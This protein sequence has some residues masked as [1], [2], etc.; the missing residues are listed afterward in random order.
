MAESMNDILH[1]NLAEKKDPDFP[2]APGGWSRDVAKAKAAEEGITLG[3]EHWKVIRFL[4]DYYHDHE[5]TDYDGHEAVIDVRDLHKA[6]E[7]QFVGQ[8]GMKHLY[9][10]FPKGPIYQGTLI[11]GLVPP[12]GSTD[13]S[14]GTAM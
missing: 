5:V 11:A 6:L 10:L 13:P 4:Q 8:G 9:L 2:H 3:E 1:P 12:E 14:F 7:A